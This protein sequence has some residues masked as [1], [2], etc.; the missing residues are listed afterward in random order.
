[1]QTNM[2]MTDRTIRAII[3]LVLIWLNMSGTF[4]GILA[5]I[6]WVVALIFIYTSIFGMCYIYKLLGIST[7]K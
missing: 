7:K 6:S 2:S 5:M 1:M 3:A 4:T